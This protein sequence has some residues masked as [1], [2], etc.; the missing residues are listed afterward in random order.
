MGWGRNVIRPAWLMRRRG[1]RP[2]TKSATTKWKVNPVFTVILEVPDSDAGVP[3][4]PGRA[5]RMP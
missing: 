1:N 3:N 4:T 5:V 2:L